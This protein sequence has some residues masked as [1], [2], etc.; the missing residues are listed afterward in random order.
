MLP[1][2]VM[3]ALLWI[4]AVS[5]TAMMPFPRHK[6]F[7]VALLALFPVVL[8]FLLWQVGWVWGVPVLL[9]ALSMYRKP[10]VYGVKRLMGR[11]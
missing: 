5:V 7:A 10:L 11:V 8:G 4:L 6:P 2:S 1:L 3:L 9:A